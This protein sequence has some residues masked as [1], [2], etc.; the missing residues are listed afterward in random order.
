MHDAALVQYRN[1]VEY[2]FDQPQCV[3]RRKLALRRQP[4][5]QAGSR[6]EWGGQKTR[7]FAFM[8]F[9]AGNRNQRRMRDQLQR[10]DFLLQPFARLGGMA[11]PIGKDAKRY[12]GTI[13]MVDRAPGLRQVA[14]TQGLLQY[15]VG[16][17]RT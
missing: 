13:P 10:R 11:E 14:L 3:G 8:E 15:V 16:D 5:H 6:N 9:S 4:P 7:P 2:G 12:F 1:N 17:L